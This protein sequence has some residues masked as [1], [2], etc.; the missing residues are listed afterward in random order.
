LHLKVYISF[1]YSDYS[2]MHRIIIKPS[3]KM[4][5][6]IK[7]QSSRI[8]TPPLLLKYTPDQNFEE[9]VFLAH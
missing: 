6:A 1:S 7:N 2:T 8:S 5:L 4:I 3:K 9:L